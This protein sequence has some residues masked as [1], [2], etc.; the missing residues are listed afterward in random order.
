MTMK[1]LTTPVALKAR[2]RWETA[3]VP[4]LVATDVAVIAA[5][6]FVA[7]FIRFGAPLSQGPQSNWLTAFSVLFILLWLTALSMFRTRSPRVIGGGIDE[8]RYVVSASFWT[9]GVIAIVALLLKL[10]IAR[11]Y[12]AVA[13][14]LGTT[15]LLLGRHFWNRWIAAERD[16]GRCQTSV[17]AIGD[18]RAVS[19]LARELMR[20]PANGYQIV[21]VGIPGYKGPLG[22]AIVVNGEEIPILGDETAALD[23]I[24]KCGAN[25]VA[26]TGA[27]HFGVDGMRRLV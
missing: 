9:F 21:G 3:Y 23:A 25:T 20:K 7:Q 19:V 24:E 6:I 11:G 14:P 26:I 17:L 27:E 5:A 13:F 12:L 2:T 16:Q 18:I 15:G 8:Y 10:E 22:K 1:T 4:R